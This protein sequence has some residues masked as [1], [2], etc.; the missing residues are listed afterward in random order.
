MSAVV[1]TVKTIAFPDHWRLHPSKAPFHENPLQTSGVPCSPLRLSAPRIGD[2]HSYIVP[3]AIYWSSVFLEYAAQ[4]LVRLS[5]IMVFTATSTYFLPAILLNPVLF[6]HSLNTILSR[7]L[8]PVTTTAAIQPLPYYNLGPSANHPH[9]NCHASD[10][11]C[12]GYTILIVSAQLLIF[13]RISQSR[14]EV[15]EKS[16]SNDPAILASTRNRERSEEY[17]KGFEVVDG[18]TKSDDTASKCKEDP[19]WWE[20]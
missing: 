13:G 9:L 11:L 18:A 19:E 10:S 5:S 15:K 17:F 2:R 12:W 8:P 16:K 7:I 1:A 4:F 14:T 6:L 20:D 3:S